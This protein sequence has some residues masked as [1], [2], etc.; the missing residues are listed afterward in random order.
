MLIPSQGWKSYGELKNLFYWSAGHA[1]FLYLLFCL[2]R[3]EQEKKKVGELVTHQTFW[4][5][6]LLSIFTCCSCLTLPLGS[7]EYGTTCK[8]TQRYHYTP[9]HLKKKYIYIYISNEISFTHEYTACHP[10]LKTNA[11]DQNITYFL[12]QN[13]LPESFEG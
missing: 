3:N 9:K 6:V 7:S 5:V 4:C 10:L 11:S 2:T 1:T 13:K 8:N 12:K